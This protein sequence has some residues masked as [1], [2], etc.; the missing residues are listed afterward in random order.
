MRRAKETALP[1]GNEAFHFFRV[2]SEGYRILLT[3]DYL[4]I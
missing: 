4:L 3:S 1:R 2:V